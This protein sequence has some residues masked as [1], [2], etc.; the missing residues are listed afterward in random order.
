MSSINYTALPSRRLFTTWA[1]SKESP[2]RPVHR[3]PAGRQ[4][5]DQPC[6]GSYP[7]PAQKKAPTEAGARM[8]SYGRSLVCDRAG[9]LQAPLNAV[10]YCLRHRLKAPRLFHAGMA[11]LRCF[12]GHQ[13][14]LIPLP[15]NRQEYDVIGLGGLN[16]HGTVDYGPVVPG[17]VLGLVVFIECLRRFSFLDRTTSI[18]SPS[19]S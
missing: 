5:R 3:F 19:S 17:V 2:R 10:A 14:P 7:A 8:R 13:S 9:G 1:R 4:I 6:S 16:D 18:G 12:Q 11:T 15:P